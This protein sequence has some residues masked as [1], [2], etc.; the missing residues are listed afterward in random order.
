M[1]SRTFS[2]DQ[3]IAAI[4]GSGGIVSTIAARVGCTWYTAR[5]YIDDHPTVRAAYDA[6]RET[7]VD[8]AESVLVRNVQIAQAKQREGESAD[9]SDVKW[10]LSRLGKDRGYTERTEIRI[11][12]VRKLSDDELRAIVAP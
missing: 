12:D 4:A 11:E 8:A 3:F 5:R 6:E 10:I 7:L 2:A 1:S 9:T